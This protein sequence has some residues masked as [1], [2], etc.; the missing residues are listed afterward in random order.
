MALTDVLATGP[1]NDPSYVKLTIKKQKK[2]TQTLKLQDIKESA[3][4]FQSCLFWF[5]IWE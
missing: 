5:C 3:A 1:S 2:K 4:D